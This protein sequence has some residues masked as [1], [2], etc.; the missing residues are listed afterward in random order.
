MKGKKQRVKLD[1]R[2]NSKATIMWEKK[3]EPTKMW[4][5]RKNFRMLKQ[6]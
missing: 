4:E 3:E 1:S 5:S 6:A 2:S